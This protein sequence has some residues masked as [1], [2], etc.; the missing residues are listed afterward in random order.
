[1]PHKAFRNCVDKFPQGRSNVADDARPGRPVEIATEATVRLVEELIGAYRRITIDSVSA[2][3]K[4][5]IS[6][7]TVSEGA[8]PSTM[9]TP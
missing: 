9:P 6:S 4:H 2:L 5:A 7:S 1:L 8:Y 3:P